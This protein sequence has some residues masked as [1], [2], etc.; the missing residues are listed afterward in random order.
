MEFLRV[1]FCL[2]LTAGSIQVAFSAS[3]IDVRD[4]GARGDGKADDTEAFE[5]AV[6]QGRARRVPVFV[7]RGTYRLRR[8]IVLEDQA[9][10]GPDAGAWCADA[11]ALPVLLPQH[12]DAPGFIL[13]AGASL[14]GIC[15]RYA[16]K[17]EPE[18]GPPAVRI[19]GIG[20]YLSRLKLMYPWDGILADGVSNVGR[21]NMEHIFIV[22]PRNIGVRVTGTWDAPTL[23]NIEVW[24][25]GP[26]PRP[27]SR[28]IGF[29]L[30]KNDLIRLSDCFVFA[31]QT[32]FLLRDTIPGCRVTG[33]TWGVLNGCATDFCSVG[34][35]VQG[36]HT[37]SI[38]GGTFWN[39]HQGLIVDG[40]RARVR[41]S[42]VELKSNG[43]PAVEVRQADQVVLSGCSLLRTMEAH[44]GPAV[45]LRGGRTTLQGCHLQ[46]IG[47]GIVMGAEVLSALVQGNTLQVG[48]R[49]VVRPDRT[50]GIRVAEN[51]EVAF[52]PP[53]GAG[54]EA[55]K[56]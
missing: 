13:R 25:A 23:R 29:D 33:G 1:L 48:G 44:A 9:L 27:L 43:A 49:T 12:R 50:E 30:G 11:D 47:D 46:S 52:A 6:R 15:I 24:N 14:Q 19:Q 55:Q 31:M 40:S 28:G 8:P 42:G 17:Q 20:V 41:L 26:V 21:L 54:Q 3:K 45:H 7:P 4:C 5:T 16:W 18:S 34:I 53:A 37:V 10:T 36:E 2:M 22:S 35:A 39:H 32:G 51:L 38:S 56:P